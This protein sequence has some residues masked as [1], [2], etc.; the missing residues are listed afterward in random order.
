M[1]LK[2]QKQD[3]GVPVESA[4]DFVLLIGAEVRN[5]EAGFSQRE[6]VRCPSVISALLQGL[7]APGSLVARVAD[8]GTNRVTLH[9]LRRMNPARGNVHF[10]EL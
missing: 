2:S 8:P 3:S 10:R 7:D 4:L 1:P 6:L 5:T 9:S